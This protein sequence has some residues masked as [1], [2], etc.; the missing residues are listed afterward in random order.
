M[1]LHAMGVIAVYA[2]LA[3]LA[4]WLACDGAE[5]P[6]SRKAGAWRRYRRLRMPTPPSRCCPRRSGDWKKGREGVG[7]SVFH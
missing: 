1:P 7:R 2:A 6:L 3:V 4:L 5:N